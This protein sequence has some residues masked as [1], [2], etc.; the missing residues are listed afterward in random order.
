MSKY[1]P[2]ML[3]TFAVGYPTA[4]GRATEKVAAVS[5]YVDAGGVLFTDEHGM[6][7]AYFPPGTALISLDA[8]RALPVAAPAEHPVVDAE[9]KLVGSVVIELGE[10]LMVD[11]GPHGPAESSD[12][13]E[14]DWR[15]ALNSARSLVID[16]GGS[17]TVEQRAAIAKKLECAARCVS[18]QLSAA[19]NARAGGV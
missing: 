18:I 16:L 11:E 6:N 17:M 5:F 12:P 4:S 10:P 9:G 14:G 3:R 15:Q 2:S 19:A 8:Q 7:T 1:D 13:Y